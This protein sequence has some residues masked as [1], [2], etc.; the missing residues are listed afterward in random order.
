MIHYYSHFLKLLISLKKIK[1]KKLFLI[2]DSNK[3]EILILRYN[4]N[5][6]LQLSKD[7]VYIKIQKIKMMHMD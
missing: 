2:S 6:N 7:N 3:L 4:N 5:N 1:K